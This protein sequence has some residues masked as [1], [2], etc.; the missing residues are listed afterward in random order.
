MPR[1]RKLNPLQ[2]PAQAG[3]DIKTVTGVLDRWAIGI[4]DVLKDAF[5]WAKKHKFLVLVVIGLI[6]MKRYWLDE[7]TDS[8]DEEDE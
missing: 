6:A 4:E 7:P 1:K 3:R 5:D 8:E 2:L